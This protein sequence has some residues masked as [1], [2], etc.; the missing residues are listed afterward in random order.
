MPVLLGWL[1]IFMGYWSLTPRGR[2][3]IA[4]VFMRLMIVMLSLAMAPW[5]IVWTVDLFHHGWVFY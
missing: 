2:R 1:I 3:G 4:S 5:L